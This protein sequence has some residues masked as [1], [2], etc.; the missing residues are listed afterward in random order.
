MVSRNSTNA[1][2]E[3]M[4][5]ADKYKPTAHK[6]WS[7]AKLVAMK[8]AN[9]APKMPAKLNVNAEPVYRTE[10]GKISDNTVPMGP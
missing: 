9:D 6:P 8:G 10:V 3:I 5:A 2:N 1:T 7:V 4:E